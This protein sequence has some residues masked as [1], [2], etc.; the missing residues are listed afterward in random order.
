LKNKHKIKLFKYNLIKTAESTSGT[1]RLDLKEELK[2]FFGL[3]QRNFKNLKG[4]ERLVSG[5]LS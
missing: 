2:P 3:Q 4:I 5:S 1:K